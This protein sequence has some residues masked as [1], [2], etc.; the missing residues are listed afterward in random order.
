MSRFSWSIPAVAEWSHRS[1]LQLLP[2]R[3]ERGR[4]ALKGRCAHIGSTT[5][6]V[7][8]R[9]TCYLDLNLGNLVHHYCPRSY[10]LY[11]GEI[12]KLEVLVVRLVRIHKSRAEPDLF[13]F[14]LDSVLIEATLD[15]PPR[16]ILYRRS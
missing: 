5:S 3:V 1:L 6:S 10:S 9:W 2:Q 15:A 7:V 11:W 8:C 13:H 4:G 14:P 16:P 12:M